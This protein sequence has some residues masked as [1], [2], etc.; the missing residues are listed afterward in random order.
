M[1][2]SITPASCLPADPTGPSQCAMMS[3]RSYSDWSH[4]EGHSPLQL[5]CGIPPMRPAT[6]HWSLRTDLQL[7]RAFCA[8]DRARSVSCEGGGGGRR[9]Y[10]GE[11]S[12]KE[13]EEEVGT[14]LFYPCKL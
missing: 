9:G 7:S 5:G 14:S 1:Q 10:E 3:C 6:F 11:G 2:R 8:T 12:V 4:R 13:G